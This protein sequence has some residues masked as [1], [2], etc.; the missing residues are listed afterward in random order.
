MKK[1]LLTATLALI[2]AVSASAVD[3]DIKY[4]GY[5]DTG[6]G[7][8]FPSSDTYDCMID[9]VGYNYAVSTTHGIQLFGGMF[10]GLG[11]EANLVS[12]N[13]Y[14][15]SYHGYEESWEIGGLVTVFAEGRYNI[16]REKKISPFVG[17]RIGGGY[18]GINEVGCFHFAPMAGC[19]FNFTDNFGLDVG[20]R[21]GMYAFS[22]DVEDYYNSYLT[23]R[24]SLLYSNLNVFVGVHF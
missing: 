10:I 22:M 4:K 12:Y 14:D 21:Y 13:E 16:L 17:L 5:V 8:M 9:G 24:S 15:T 18:N 3:I 1:L 19:T 23:N 11:L 6:G 7:L 20:L 2:T